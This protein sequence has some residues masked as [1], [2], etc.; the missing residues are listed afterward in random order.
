MSLESF[1]SF[2]KQRPSLNDYVLRKEMTWQQFYDMY[3]LYG[4]RNDIWNKYINNVTNITNTVSIKDIINNL[5]TIDLT[6]IQK[7]ITS[8][9]KGISYLQDMT[10]SKD[11][12]EKKSSY[13]PRPIYKHLD[14]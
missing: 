11:T 4:D 6:E 14:D 8:I 2:V 3:E 7:G 1:K 9:Q 12:E 5:K 10:R 13:E